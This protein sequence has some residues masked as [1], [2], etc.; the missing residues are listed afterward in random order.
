MVVYYRDI[1]NFSGISQTLAFKNLCIVEHCCPPVYVLTC[2]SS[3]YLVT[4]KSD[5]LQHNLLRKVSMIMDDISKIIMVHQKQSSLRVSC[6]RSI[7]YHNCYSWN[8]V[9]LQA[10]ME[11][12]KNG[13]GCSVH[14]SV[15]QAVWKRV[16][17]YDG[18]HWMIVG[19]HHA[20]DRKVSTSTRC[21]SPILRHW[22]QSKW[23]YIPI[24]F[25]KMWAPKLLG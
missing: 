13:T 17:G 10:S 20:I 16:S 19:W 18:R 14:N 7:H 3:E 4:H 11:L 23:S 12:D 1:G 22:V 21:G 25:K 8:R 5:G 9:T 15:N 2:R 6:P 24:V